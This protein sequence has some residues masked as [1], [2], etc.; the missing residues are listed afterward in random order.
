MRQGSIQWDV[1]GLAETWLDEMSETT[2]RIAGYTSVCASRKT[3]SG[4]GVALLIK[5][6][7]SYRVRTDISV[8]I[9]GTHTP[10]THLASVTTSPISS[11]LSDFESRNVT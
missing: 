8:F 3:K 6:G 7:M 4:G 11:C 5:E 9:E 1:I 2:M 10:E